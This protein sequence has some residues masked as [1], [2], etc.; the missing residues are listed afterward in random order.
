MLTMARGWD[1]IGQQANQLSKLMCLQHE[2]MGDPSWLSHRCRLKASQKQQVFWEL[3]RHQLPNTLLLYM[4]QTQWIAACCV[5][6]GLRSCVVPMLTSAHCWKHL[7]RACELKNC[8][9]EQWKKMARYD[10]SQFLLHHVHL[11]C[12]EEM[13]PGHASACLAAKDV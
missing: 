13:A 12:V 5:Y 9:T 10:E 3:L 11:L 4:W 1:Y 6:T 7:Q 8:I 2:K